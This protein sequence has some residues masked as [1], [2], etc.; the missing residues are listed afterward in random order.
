MNLDD[1]VGQW[2]G[3][4]V[5]FHDE[6]LRS[7]V[8]PVDMFPLESRCATMKN[9]QSSW[10][11][12][13]SSMLIALATGLVFVV[14]AAGQPSNSTVTRIEED[15]EMDVVFAKDDLGAPQMF[16]LMSPD[17]NN[18]EYFTFEVNFASSPEPE[19]GGLQVHAYVGENSYDFKNPPTDRS[20]ERVHEVIRWTQVM[21]LENDSLVFSIEDF[22]S[23]SLGNFNDDSMLEVAL[24]S[25]LT[26]LSSYSHSYS[27][28]QAGI[29]Y[30]RNR[31]NSMMLKRVR[32]YDGNTLVNENAVDVEI[33]HE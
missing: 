10:L 13:V 4:D 17:N 33:V 25:G 12:S 21:K 2:V 3:D 20:L 29:P 9:S 15:W 19:N 32:Y 16:T 28:D 8:D 7:R 1:F 24:P 22:R 5:V 26:D 31:V 14:S 18:G 11:K 6:W 27:A 23:R 30:A